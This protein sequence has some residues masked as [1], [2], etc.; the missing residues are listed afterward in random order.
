MNET[1]KRLDEQLIT[2]TEKLNDITDPE[3][4]EHQGKVVQ[5]LAVAKNVEN[6]RQIE[7]KFKPLELLFT[8]L[9]AIGTLLAAMAKF[10]EV[11][12][13]HNINDRIVSVEE[14]TYVNSQALDTK[15]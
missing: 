15:H 3:I 9:A 8:G 12:A 4:K 6:K 2:E 5:Q 10:Y 14:H 1:I 13:R 7:T 11:W